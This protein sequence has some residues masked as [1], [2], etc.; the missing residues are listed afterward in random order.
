LATLR[1]LLIVSL[2][3]SRTRDAEAEVLSRLDAGGDHYNRL[4]VR[5][6]LELLRVLGVKVMVFGIIT[7]KCCT[8]P[9]GLGEMLA[10][11]L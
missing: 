3:D 8:S 4:R 1:A 10:S 9:S 2:E 5:H 7:T 11:P 6:R